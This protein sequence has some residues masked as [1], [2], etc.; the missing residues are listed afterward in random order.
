MIEFTCPNCG[1]SYSFSD[2]FAGRRMVCAGCKN[3]ITVPEI[4]TSP[5][6]PQ[7]TSTPPPTPTLTPTQTPT[8]TPTSTPT[9][10]TPSTSPST[11]SNSPPLSSTASVS[12]SVSDSLPDVVSSDIDLLAEL[13]SASSSVAVDSV[14]NKT[15]SVISPND[16]ETALLAAV[17]T[18]KIQDKREAAAR[19]KIPPPPPKPIIKTE[20]EKKL[21]SKELIII[22]TI[23]LLM[24]VTAIYFIFFFDW[25]GPDARVDL[26]KRLEEHRIKTTI[27]IGKKDSEIESLRGRSLQSWTSTCDA[28]DAFIMTIGDIDTKNRDVLELDWNIALDAINED[29]KRQIAIA[30]DEIKNSIP[31]AEANLIKLKSIATDD[32]TKAEADELATDEAIHDAANL[33]AE[34]QFFESEITKLKQ[35]IATSPQDRPAVSFPVFD[36][37]ALPPR[38]TTAKLDKDWTEEYYN[39]FSFSEVRQGNYFTTFDSM[40]RLFGNRS[41]R[42]TLIDRTPVTIHFP[43]S[44]RT[45]NDLRIVRTFNFAIRFPDL[46]DAIMIGEERHQG[47]FRE[48]QIRFTNNSGYVD[49]KTKS[50]EY[51]DAVFYSGRGKFIVIEFSLE[52][53]EFWN[54]SD[55][56]DK[57]K[58]S[59]I[60]DQKEKNEL[61]ED[62]IKAMIDE[63]KAKELDREAAALSFFTQ[64]DK[65]EFRLTPASSRTTFWIDG[66]S[67]SDNLNQTKIDL[68]KA[69][70]I[71]RGLQELEIENRKK[72]RQRSALHSL[73]QIKGFQ[74]WQQPDL[75]PNSTT[76]N[77]SQNIEYESQSQSQSQKTTQ[78]N[79]QNKSPNDATNNNAD[80][81]AETATETVADKGKAAFFKWILNDAKGRIK[82]NYNGRTFSFWQGVKIPDGVENYEIEQVSILNYEITAAQLDWVVSFRSLKRLELA[83]AGL[84]DG[85]VVKLSVLDLLETLNL[86]NNQ[87]T[88]EALQGIKTLRKLRELD[89]SGMRTSVKGIESLGAFKS[90]VKLNLSNSEFDSTDLNYCV[91]L[92]ELEVLNL[93]GTKVGDRITGIMQMFFKLREIDL[94][95]TRISNN[96]I[97]P[98]AN[99]NNL[100]ILRLDATELDDNC[101]ESI[102]KIKNLKSISAKKTKIT[103]EAIKQKLQKT[104]IKFEL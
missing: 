43:S 88:F 4:S 47:Q 72:R 13:D 67:V 68:A 34:L 31:A 60:I 48:I 65:V 36:K 101:L 61:T 18:D 21:V 79:K 11:I 71:K 2:R 66:I 99:I 90:L 98:L 104:N 89:V 6:T 73:S 58:L 25:L 1:K 10:P 95:K 8:L 74:Y 35:Q 76:P 9:S 37:A 69:N 62:E 70:A 20:P 14:S 5:S 83:G 93:A 63:T 102:T 56:F 38:D 44:N 59:K 77:D 103:K 28:I 7:T 32:V 52:G 17:F 96:A 97:E 51:C 45:K 49:F 50:R 23:I 84:R 33:R 87:L 3:N 53:D 12:V 100:E 85:D 29:G 41:L 86:A 19:A 92:S 57:T 40:R 80:K 42:I 27:A 15:N 94:S 46:T 64:V 81:K 26:L 78:T 30:R 39:Q 75:D 54:R 91:T 16:V 55:N 22:V 82:A 24:A